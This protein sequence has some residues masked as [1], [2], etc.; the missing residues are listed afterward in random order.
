MPPNPQFPA[1]L[2]TSTGKILNRKVQFLCSVHFANFCITTKKAH[3]KGVI[4]WRTPKIPVNI[5]NWLKA[6]G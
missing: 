5:K 6:K 4:L 2:V 1:D 3:K